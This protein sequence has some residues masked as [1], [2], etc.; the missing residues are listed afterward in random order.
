MIGYTPNRE[1]INLLVVAEDEQAVKTT[2]WFKVPR[3]VDVWI[4]RNVIHIPALCVRRATG[5]NTRC[6]G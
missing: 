3:G 1:G 4:D 6:R 2:H 5:D